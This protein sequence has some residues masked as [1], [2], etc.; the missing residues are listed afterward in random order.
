MNA[1]IASENIYSY[2]KDASLI[3]L[4]LAN[5]TPIVGVIFFHWSIFNIF[6]LYWL[7]NLIVVFYSLLK[8][9]VAG[10]YLGIALGLFMIFYTGGFMLFFLILILVIFGL[11]SVQDFH[12]LRDI[13]P[14]IKPYFSIVAWPFISLFISHGYSFVTN[15]LGK[16]EYAKVNMD[17]FKK[18]QI[19]AKRPV[20]L[21]SFKVGKYLSIPFGRILILLITVLCGGFIVLIFKARII[22]LILLVLIKIILDIYRH[23]RHHAKILTTN[24]SDPSTELSSA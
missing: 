5:L 1:E 14:D 22:G 8:M 17:D 20:D 3:F 24:F 12:G 16:K 23:N 11:P 19:N 15:F 6:F 10:K 7:E 13:Y 2:E 18:A 21:D 4:I 9:A